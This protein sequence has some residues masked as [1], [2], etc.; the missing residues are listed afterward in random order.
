VGPLVPVLAEAG[1]ADDGAGTPHRFMW[2]TYRDARPWLKTRQSESV[3]K[4]RHPKPS[5]RARASQQEG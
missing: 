5:V 2:S 1:A 4:P 3:A